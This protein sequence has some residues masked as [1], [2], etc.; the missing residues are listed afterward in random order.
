MRNVKRYWKSFNWQKIWCLLQKS[1]FVVCF[2]EQEEPK[3]EKAEIYGRIIKNNICMVGIYVR[4]Q[5]N[6]VC[7]RCD[8]TH[9]K[10][11]LLQQT[12][13]F[14]PIKTLPVSFYVSHHILL[15]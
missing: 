9:N 12:P 13:Y 11:T 5:W 3:N 7:F 1:K 10:F 8:E 2:I 15:W 6:P 14:L 4:L